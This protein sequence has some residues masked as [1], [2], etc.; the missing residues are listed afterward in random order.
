M[1]MRRESQGELYELCDNSSYNF[2][3]YAEFT[4]Y[5]VIIYTVC[6]DTIHSYRDFQ[7]EEVKFGNKCSSMQPRELNE[8]FTCA[9]FLT[10]LKSISVQFMTEL[11][12]IRLFSGRC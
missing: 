2:S 5:T 11:D 4:V 7:L 3:S 8:L 12:R 10:I 1:A 6:A 9:E